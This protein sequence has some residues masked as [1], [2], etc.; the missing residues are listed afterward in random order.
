MIRWKDTDDQN[1]KLKKQIELLKKQGVD[2]AEVVILTAFRLENS[3]VVVADN[4]EFTNIMKYKG[5]EKSVVILVDM[6]PDMK[7]SLREDLIYTA[8]S[9]AVSKLILLVKKGELPEYLQN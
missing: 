4:I 8:S 6:Q 5:L 2:L 1:A 9:R 7:F 3:K